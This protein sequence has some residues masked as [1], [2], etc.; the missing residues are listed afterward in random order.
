MRYDDG[1]IGVLLLTRNAEQ[2]LAQCLGPVFKSPLK[3]KVLV[4][5]TAS[6]DRTRVI[7][8][9]MGAEVI[10][11]Q[12]AEFNHGATRE[13]G[14]KMLGTGIVVMM[15]QDS[16]PLDA[17]MI[18]RLI[19]PVQA[20]E[21]AVSYARQIPRP[22]AGLIEAFQRYYNY[23]ER[24]QIR[25]LDD[26]REFGVYTFF[27]S[28]SCAAWSN[29]A[30]DEAGGFP[31]TLS[32]EDYITVA[33]LLSR[34]H[35]IAYVA[36][37]QFYHSH[38]YT[39][40]QEFQRYFDTGYVRAENS[41]IK[42]LVGGDESRGFN[43]SRAMIKYILPRQPWLIPRIFFLLLAKWLGYRCGVR[44]YMLPPRLVRWASAQKYYWH[45]NYVRSNF[46]QEKEVR[47]RD[48]NR[49]I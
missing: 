8:S 43:F 39:L 19:K 30:L 27:C 11:I 29:A 44:A 49:Y 31:V 16:Y 7:A 23:P 20:G 28:N 36:E 1:R 22:G 40:W 6:S 37:A 4:I 33:R 42:E 41:W 24:R 5:D 10:T 13:K 2:H 17:G 48:E 38:S 12:P 18:A 46:H 35:R 9:Q 3:P 34:G 26:R 25:S 15:T 21:A 14:R 47:K 45:S 32:N